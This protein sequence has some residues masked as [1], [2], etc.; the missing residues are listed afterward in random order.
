MNSTLSFYHNFQRIT[1]TLMKQISL[2]TRPL[3][4]KQKIRDNLIWLPLINSFY[5]SLTV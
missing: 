2:K 5:Y 1:N 4:P 3:L